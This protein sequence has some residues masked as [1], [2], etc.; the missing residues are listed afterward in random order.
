MKNPPVSAEDIRDVGSILGWKDPLEELSG[1]PLQYS[2]S[3][4]FIGI[5]AWWAMVHSV[6]K[7][8]HN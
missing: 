1:N 3:E 7:T 8:A 4:N 2:W 6:S 5:G